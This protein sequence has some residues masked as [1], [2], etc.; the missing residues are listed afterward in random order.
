MRM[1][2]RRFSSAKKLAKFIRTSWLVLLPLGSDCWDYLSAVS[3]INAKVAVESENVTLGINLRHAHET[4]IGQRHRDTRVARHQLAEC[5]RVILDFEGDAKQTV[6]NLLQDHG[7]ADAPPFNQKAGFRNHR[8]AGQERWGQRA[9]LLHRPGMVPVTRA[10]HRHER[11]GIDQDI[12][13][14]SPNLCKC[15]GLLA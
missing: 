12:A 10:N 8:F 5:G 7:S 11:S 1:T 2:L 14:D 4:R 3:A 6:L 13:Q 15:R 9:E